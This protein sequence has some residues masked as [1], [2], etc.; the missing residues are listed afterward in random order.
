M[1]NT[2]PNT[3]ES[4]RFA[5][6]VTYTSVPAQNSP[7]PGTSTVNLSFAPTS[8]SGN[9]ADSN[10]PLPRFVA[11][12]NAA[13]QLG[14]GIDPKTIPNYLWD[15][16]NPLVLPVGKKVRFLIT[17]Q[18]VIHSWWVFDFAIKKDAIPGIVNESWT[19][20]DVPGTYR[21]VCAELCGRDHGFMPI[22]VKALPETEYKAWLA[23]QKGVDVASRSPAPA[24]TEAAPA[25]VA[26]PAATE[27]SVAPASA[28]ASAATAAAPAP[29]EIAATATAAVSSAPMSKD[30]LM[31]AGK[32]VFEAN[33]QACHQANGQGLPPNFPSLVGSKVVNGPAKA[34][35]IHAIKGKGLMPPFGQLSD[36]DLA[37]AVTYERNSWGNKA[38][39]AQPA[40]VKAAR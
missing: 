8:I 4:F 20:I 12:S 31:T 7:F 27:V 25:A 18:D 6:Y 37:A 24:L 16:N 35:I 33:C 17:A 26:M 34:H 29:T 28:E 38:S 23:Q 14:S 13:R 36:A 10:I 3:N 21:G 1:V 5:V 39:I 40:D 19:K 22:V 9:A 32:K 11:D 30:A 15:V 2:N